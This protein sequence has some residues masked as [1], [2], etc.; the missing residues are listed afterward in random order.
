MHRF[1]DFWGLTAASVYK[2]TMRDVHKDEL[3]VSQNRNIF[4]HVLHETAAQRRDGHTARCKQTPAH[5]LTEKDTGK[6]I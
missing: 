4:A 2:S 3:L 6:K 1:V 5:G